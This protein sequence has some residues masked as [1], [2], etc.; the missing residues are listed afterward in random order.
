M[1]L[2]A[3]PPER[4]IPPQ[5]ERSKRALDRILA[6]LEELLAEGSFDSIGMVDIA[7]RAGVAVGSIYAR[8]ADKR[9]LLIGMHDRIH[10]STQAG[11]RR[12][13]DPAT[14]ADRDMD[15]LLRGMIRVAMRY[16]G[17]HSNVLRA[18]SANPPPE[19]VTTLGAEVQDFKRA[20]ATL[21]AEREMVVESE[22]LQ[23]AVDA[24]VNAVIA[25]LMLRGGHIGRT[26]FL[27]STN[28]EL[29]RQL[30]TIA[31]ALLQPALNPERSDP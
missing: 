23:V 6:A 2:H 28:R 22:R 11:R 20:L 19:L 14:W 1:N 24:A 4:V 12:M 21:L 26:V 18:I 3:N 31:R 5:Q 9:S 16:Y 13:V 25:I 15:Q 7:A 30:H 27:T 29:A 10:N 17:E 8:F